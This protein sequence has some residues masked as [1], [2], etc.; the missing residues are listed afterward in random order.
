MAT[1]AVMSKHCDGALN[2]IHSI[3]R[4]LATEQ[5]SGKDSSPKEGEVQMESTQKTSYNKRGN[6]FKRGNTWT[7]ICYPIDPKTGQPKPKWCGGF[8]SEKDAK[9]AL[10]NAEAE[11]CTGAYILSSNMTVGQYVEKWFSHHKKNLKPNTINGYESNI[12]LHIT[13]ILGAKKLCELN[14]FDIADFIEKLKAKNLSPRSIQYIRDV[15]KMALNEAV[16][17][18]LIKKNPCLR[19]DI[20]KQKRYRSVVL[21]VAQAKRLLNAAIDS[22]V[23]F[24][25]ITTL[26]LGLRRGEVLGIEYPDFDFLNETV[27][28]QR[29]VTYT[30]DRSTK[31]KD[32]K[33]TEYGLIDLKTEE[34]NRVL[35]LPK[36]VVEA[37]QRR[38]K[39]I[40]E[41]KLR[42]GSSYADK[43]LMC[44]LGNGDCVSPQTLYH[45][46]KRLLKKAELPD[47]R[48]HDLRHSCATLLL[49][50]DV[51]LAVISKMLGHSTIAITAD[52]YCDVLEKKKQVADLFEAKVFSN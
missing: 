19:V 42:T 36:S 7:Y 14:K 49:D 29:Q 50:W 15:L 27:H 25:V 18:G 38:R 3:Q 28:I 52:I 23:E 10:K 47:I 41:Q 12:R 16:D 20:P 35:N 11:I 26:S 33:K 1:A 34:S 44:A 2:V 40:L 30:H 9:T 32:S 24:E 13:P 51:P 46:F 5:L 39:L 31:D 4:T 8:K 17:D 37:A 22:D 21:D 6:P 43:G 48:F 45:R